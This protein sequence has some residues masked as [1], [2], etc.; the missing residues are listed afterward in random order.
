MADENT[1]DIP[2]QTSETP[3][4]KA[5]PI[6]LVGGIVAGLALGAVVGLLVLGPR[7]TARAATAPARAKSAAHDSAAKHD[8]K[9][10][11]IYLVDNLVLNP[12]GSN[13]TRFLLVTVALAVK[14]DNAAAQ[15][16]ARDAEMRDMILRLL[17]S[18]T[19]DQVSEASQRDELRA[20]VLAAVSRMF[21]PGTIQ[22]VYFPQFVI[23]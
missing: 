16:K 2:E 11:T 20:E 19:A 17:G 15:L 1:N 10:P 13:G 8:A 12:A 5:L 9:A 14:D 18:K 23:Q 22:K 4:K 7:L 3:K 6:V 21:P